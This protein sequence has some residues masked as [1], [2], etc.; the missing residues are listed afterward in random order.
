MKKI[1]LVAESGSDITPELAE[2][3]GIYVPPMH[4]NF[5]EETFD[6]GTFPVQKIVDYYRDGGKLPKTSGCTPGDFI[7]VFDEIHEKYPE[8]QIL[9]LAYSAVTTCSFQSAVIA[10]DE[11]DYVTMLDTKQVSGGQG[12]IVISLARELEKNP[13]M[14][15]EEAVAKANEFIEKGKMC[16]TPDNLEFLRAGGRVSN[17]A[18]LGAQLLNLHPCIEL[19]DGKLTATKKYRGKMNK[20][21]VQMLKE[22]AEKYDLD[23][24]ILWFLYTIDFA[25]EVKEEVTHAAEELGFEEIVWTQCNGVITTHAGPKSFGFAGF[26]K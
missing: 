21:A 2:K 19:I 18:F 9:Y 10:S 6:D 20:V 13:D 26:S 7:T 14:T 11:R 4:V 8:A 3:Y 25:E 1:I 15:M 16:F 17:V 23:R 12:V 22:Y 24:R 5:G